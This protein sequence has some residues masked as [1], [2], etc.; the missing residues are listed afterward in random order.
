MAEYLATDANGPR[1]P[2]INRRVSP[3]ESGEYVIRTDVIPII[4]DAARPNIGVARLYE[5]PITNYGGAG[6]L[7]KDYASSEPWLGATTWPPGNKTFFVAPYLGRVYFNAAQIGSRASIIYSSSGSLV[8]AT[9]INHVNDKATSAAAPFRKIVVPAN[10]QLVM[11]REVA[12]LVV[13]DNGSGVLVPSP[14]WA[15]IELFEIENVETYRS[16]VKNSSAEAKTAY[17]KTFKHHRKDQ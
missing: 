13:G 9:D 6:M 11:A 17:V 10:G 4:E 2:V 8:D 15:S 14:S 3:T 1:L 16:I 12:L 5:A 7:V